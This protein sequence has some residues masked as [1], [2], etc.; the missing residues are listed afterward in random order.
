MQATCGQS[1]TSQ[2][3]PAVFIPLNCNRKLQAL[4]YDILPAATVIMDYAIGLGKLLAIGQ[5]FV[6]AQIKGSRRDQEQ[7][8]GAGP[9]AQKRS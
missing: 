2:T 8:G 7:G 4:V 3:P 6:A 9:S 5:F 1:V